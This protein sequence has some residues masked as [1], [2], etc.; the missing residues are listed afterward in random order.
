MRT[1]T[2]VALVAAPA[3]A[4]TVYSWEDQDGVHYTD[5]LSQVPKKAKVEAQ[6]IE[7]APSRKTEVAAAPAPAT[8]TAART[9][10]PTSEREWR[11]AFITAHRRLATLKQ[12]L[13]AL[14]TSLP[15]ATT[16][17]TDPTP[18]SAVP[19]QVQGPNGVVVITPPAQP[20]TR[21]Q[22]NPLHDRVR[23]HIEQKKVEL[24]DAEVDLEQL[25]RRASYEAV[26][27][28]W[29]RGW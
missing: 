19:V 29:R 8:A 16:C 27:R 14:Q 3:F 24:R 7:A 25:D 2:L 12:E 23:V 6:L 4:Q 18:P 10:T 13:A 1:L 17:V 22:P 15:A 21:C 5:D 11:D 28:E 26:P 20:Q 9:P